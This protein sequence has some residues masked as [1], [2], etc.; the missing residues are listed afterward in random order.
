MAVSSDCAPPATSWT[1]S[2]DWTADMSS[3]EDISTRLEAL[4]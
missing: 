1:I 4:Y 2:V 3:S